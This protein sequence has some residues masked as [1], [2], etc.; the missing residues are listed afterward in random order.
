[1]TINYFFLKSNNMK[2][3]NLS[4]NKEQLWDLFGDHEVFSESPEIL[5]NCFEEWSHMHGIFC[6]R[7]KQNLKEEYT[8]SKKIED[9]LEN[10][11]CTNT[12]FKG[13]QI[14]DNYETLISSDLYPGAYEEKR[15][16]VLETHEKNGEPHDVLENWK[17][18]PQDIWKKNYTDPNFR[19]IIKKCKK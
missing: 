10:S 6:Y 1:M 12:L 11:S 8:P 15:V 3:Q 2:S 19:K 4:M 18:I 17:S 9:L 7:L 5:F 14:I 16:W 13:V